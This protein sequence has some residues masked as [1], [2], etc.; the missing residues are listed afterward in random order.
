MSEPT[1]YQVINGPD[2]TSLYVLVPSEQHMASGERPD[3]DVTLPHEVVALAV[4]EDKASCGP[5]ANTW[6]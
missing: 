5:G 4:V 6:A 2:G 1:R 3:E